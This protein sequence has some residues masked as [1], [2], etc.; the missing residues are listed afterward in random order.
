MDRELVLVNLVL[1]SARENLLFAPSRDIFKCLTVNE[2]EKGLLARP[3]AGDQVGCIVADVF[4][5]RRTRMPLGRSQ[6]VDHVR[7]LFFKIGLLARDHV[8]IHADGN[9]VYLIPQKV[10]RWL[11][12]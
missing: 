9:H 1:W 11:G 6:R 10:S 8:I 3:F 5:Q 4:P 12:R 2:V 7:K